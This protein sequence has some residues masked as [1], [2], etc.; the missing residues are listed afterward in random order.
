[1]LDV[2]SRVHKIKKMIIRDTTSTKLQPFD[3]IPLVASSIAEETWLLCFDEFQVT[4]IADA[5]ILKRLFTELFDNGIIVVATSNRSPD[6]LYKNGLY[7]IFNLYLFT[8][9]YI[10]IYAL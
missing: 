2:H 8:D 9:I 6:D 10:Y 5:M 3:P 7:F 1:M 4:D